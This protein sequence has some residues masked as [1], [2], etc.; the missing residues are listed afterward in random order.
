[1]STASTE[2][3]TMVTAMMWIDWTIGMIQDTLWIIML[4][5]VWASQSQKL[6]MAC[7]ILIRLRRFGGCR[8][9]CHKFPINEEIIINI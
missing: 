3:T 2:P 8:N 4:I 9:A 1:M 7:S 5:G 6:E